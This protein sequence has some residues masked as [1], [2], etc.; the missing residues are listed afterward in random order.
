LAFYEIN[1]DK[2]YVPT[3]SW[4]FITITIKPNDECK[5]YLNTV[6]VQT[7]TTAKITYSG[8]PT[9]CSTASSV[10]PS[11]EEF[12]VNTYPSPGYPYFSE[13]QES[14][15]S[16]TYPGIYPDLGSYNKLSTPISTGYCI[17][18]FSFFGSSD[19]FRGFYGKI[20]ELKILNKIVSS[21]EMNM[22][23]NDTYN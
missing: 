20:D 13:R 6:L 15:T 11:Y 2:F 3:G 16:R 19:Q 8:Y 17:K 23:Y 21:L 5:V 1:N 7:T 12:P 14:E 10:I 4:N 9:A 22:L 18:D